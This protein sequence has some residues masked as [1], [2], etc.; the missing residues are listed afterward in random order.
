MDCVGGSHVG[1]PAVFCSRQ[2]K[3]FLFGAAID[4]KIS[5][6]EP[7]EW[8]GC[9]SKAYVRAVPFTP[10]ATPPRDFE[11]FNFWAW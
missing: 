1:P 11:S 5:G 10:C 8:Q 9:T 6:T 2:T 3:A 7:H 4:G